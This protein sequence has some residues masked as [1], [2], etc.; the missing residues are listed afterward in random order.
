MAKNEPSLIVFAVGILVLVYLFG[1]YQSSVFAEFTR[2]FHENIETVML[3][4][5]VMLVALYYLRI[6]GISTETDIENENE[7]EILQWI[8]PSF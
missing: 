3:I 6:H 2:V 8:A 5:L 7:S 4:V 1:T